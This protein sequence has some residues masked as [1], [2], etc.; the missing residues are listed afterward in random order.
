MLRY[1]KSLT[2]ARNVGFGLML[3]AGAMFVAQ[4][5]NAQ[6][7]AEPTAPPPTISTSASKLGLSV[8]RAH[9]CAARQ[10]ICPVTKTRQND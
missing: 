6:A 3:A 2:F 4:S 8:T 10:W 1:L 7:K 9:P 5:A